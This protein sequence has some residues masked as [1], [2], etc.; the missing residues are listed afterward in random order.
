MRSIAHQPRRSA[1]GSAVALVLACLWIAA[2]LHAHESMAPGLHDAT[3]RGCPHKA[4]QGPCS[5][6]RLAQDISSPALTVQ[7]LATPEVRSESERATYAA[8]PRGRSQRADAARAPPARL[9]SHV[10]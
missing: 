7:R 9:L 10:A 2:P 8:E 5:L 4:D 3:P 6:C 1:L